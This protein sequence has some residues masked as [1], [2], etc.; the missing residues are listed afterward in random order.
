LLGFTKKVSC[1][2][3]QPGRG[4]IWTLAK[5]QGKRVTTASSIYFEWRRPRR[6]TIRIKNGNLDTLGLPA[7]S[8][9][10]I[11]IYFCIHSRFVRLNSQVPHNLGLSVLRPH[12]SSDAISDNKPRRNESRQTTSWQQGFVQVHHKWAEQV[13]T[14]KWFSIRF[15]VQD[16]PETWGT[17][18]IM[19]ARSHKSDFFMPKSILFM[20][21]SCIRYAI[22]RLSRG[23]FA[24]LQRQVFLRPLFLLK[25]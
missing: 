2:C 20:C 9:G 8:Q 5:G 4:E 16:P 22:Y 6:S 17:I 24:S 10:R 18:Y 19:K 12:P 11:S 15:R 25:F 23:V 14:L 3:Q 21:V 1:S 7:I 13:I